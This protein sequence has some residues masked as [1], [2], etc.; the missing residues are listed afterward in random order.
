MKI[1]QDLVLAVAIK[2]NTNTPNAQRCFQ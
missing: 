1:N 2:P